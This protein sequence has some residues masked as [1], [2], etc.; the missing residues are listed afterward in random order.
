RLGTNTENPNGNLVVRLNGNDRF[1]FEGNNSGSSFMRI[2]ASNTDVGLLQGLPNNNVT[3]STDISNSLLILND[4]IYVNKTAN[5]TG[6]GTT[7]PSERLDVNGNTKIS[8]AIEIGS[9]MNISGEVNRPTTG[10]YNLLPVCYG[11][12]SS[13]GSLLGGTDNITGTSFDG[14]P[15]Y[16]FRVDCAAITTSSIVQITC[17]GSQ[18]VSVLPVVSVYNGHFDVK[19]FSEFLKSLS[20]PNI[21]GTQ[22]AFHFIVYNP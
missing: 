13:G 6:I 15:F 14:S 20:D 12:V 2:K 8:G 19:F 18:S 10:S 16:N 3:L 7:T 5:R 4:E 17:A 1:S 21:I 9:T 22:T 11:R